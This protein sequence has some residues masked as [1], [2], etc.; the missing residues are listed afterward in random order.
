V[1]GLRIVTTLT[2]AALAVALGA[3]ASLG[4]V[5]I[6]TEGQIG[7]FTI[8]DSMT[9]PGGKCI[10]DAG[11]PGDQGNDIDIMEVAGPKVFARDRSSERDRQ[12]VGVKVIFQH[13]VNE[14][15]SGGFVNGEVTD[16]VKRVA[17]DD[18]AAKF[19]KETWVVP[20]EEDFHFRALVKIVW[21]KPG[22]T[23]QKQGSTKQR[24]VFY[25]VVHGGPQG[26]EQDR[27]LPEP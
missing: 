20:I 8:P 9:T 6:S 11:G 4:A 21:F 22:T 14:G 15:G 23:S 3:S 17:F 19:K 7:T 18:Q 24:Y 1:H 16:L 27:C 5:P 26:V 25:R 2:A 13:S 10:Y 12:T